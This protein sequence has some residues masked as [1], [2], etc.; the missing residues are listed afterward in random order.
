MKTMYT[1][2]EENNLAVVDVIDMTAL[3]ETR[4]K[5]TKPMFLI[6]R[7][8]TPPA[9]RGR[10]LAQKL[11]TEVTADA[12]RAKAVLMLFPQPYPGTDEAKLLR[13]YSKF[14]FETKSDGS[15]VREP[16]NYEHIFLT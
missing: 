4:V 15:M 3:A 14:G 7:V 5:P 1:M 9:I 11:L 8:N 16:Q 13:L 6:S 12:D 10:G 2:Q